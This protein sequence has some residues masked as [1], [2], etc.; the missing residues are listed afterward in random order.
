MLGL[1]KKAKTKKD[2]KKEYRDFIAQSVEDGSF[3]KDS[4]EWYSFYYLKSVCD[5][6]WLVIIISI[7]AVILYILLLMAEDSF[8]L[9]RKVP[10]VINE[11]DSVNLIPIISSLKESTSDTN[12]EEPII[13]L[14][15]IKYLKEREEYDFEKMTTKDLGKKFDIIKNNSS[16]AEFRKFRLSLDLDNPKSPIKY[17]GQD[18]NK[19]VK[20]ISFSFNKKKNDD[21]ISKARKFMT[22]EVPKS[23]DIRYQLITDYGDKKTVDNYLARIEFKFPYINQENINKD[24]NFIVTSYDLFTINKK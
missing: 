19:E 8:P 1:K 9:V 23:A 20:M 18:I 3:F 6:S 15:L 7:N 13:K 22:V 2:I 21:F 17:F 24:L 5:R 14:L 16:A 11:K 10:I 4:F 12:L